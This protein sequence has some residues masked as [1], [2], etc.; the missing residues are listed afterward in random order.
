M[1]FSYVSQ[2]IIVCYISV[3]FMW[4]TLS[5]HIKTSFIALYTHAYL[6]KGGAVAVWVISFVTV[7]LQNKCV[8]GIL[9]ENDVMH[10]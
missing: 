1:L 2:S 10:S 9:N 4:L 8:G 3:F 6:M 7:V 5:R